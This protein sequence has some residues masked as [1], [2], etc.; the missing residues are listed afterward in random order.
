[1][2][3]A[4]PQVTI[5]L[6]ADSGFAIPRLYAWCEHHGVDYTIGLVPN[7]RLV[8]LAAPLLAQAL[9]DSAARGEPKYD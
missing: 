2:R 4:W 7:R 3:G 8:L 5:E 1:L 6:R 9:A